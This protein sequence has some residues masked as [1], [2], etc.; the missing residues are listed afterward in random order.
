VRCSHLNPPLFRCSRGGSVG[1]PGTAWSLYRMLI[2]EIG[3]RLVLRQGWKDGVAGIYEAFYWPLSNLCAQAG[4]WELQQE[5][6][7]DEQYAR[8]EDTTW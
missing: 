2:R 8:L 7:I 3:F 1:G 4:L 5:P 6:S